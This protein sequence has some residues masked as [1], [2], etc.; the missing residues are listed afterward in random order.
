MSGDASPT[1]IAEDIDEKG[2]LV[3]KLQSGVLKKISAGDV[4]LLR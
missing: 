1:G 3:L 2:M 4:T